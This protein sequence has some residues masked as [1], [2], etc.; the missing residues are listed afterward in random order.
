MLIKTR[1]FNNSVILI[2]LCK[3]RLTVIILCLVKKEF[4]LLYRISH[5][6][7]MHMP[8]KIYF[9]YKNWIHESRLLQR[10]N[11]NNHVEFV[12][13]MWRFLNFSIIKVYDKVSKMSVPRN[14]KGFQ[15]LRNKKNAK[16]CLRKPCYP[17][18]LL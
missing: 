5:K 2:S 8:L 16:P 14:V 1:V 13:K 18:W 7:E 3:F 15:R 9:T 11:A 6:D 17:L 12:S 10:Q 4:N